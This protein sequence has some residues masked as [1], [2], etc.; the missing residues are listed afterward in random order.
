MNYNCDFLKTFDGCMKPSQVNMAQLINVIETNVSQY[1]YHYKTSLKDYPEITIEVTNANIPHLLGLSKN[2]HN[3]LPD[4][5]AGVIFEGLKDDWTLDN[6]KKGDNFWFTENQDKIIGVLLLY[7]IFHV[8]E[9]KIYSTKH[10]INQPLG[11]KFKRDNIYFIIFKLAN[12]KDYSVELSPINNSENTYFPRSLKIN[13]T[14]FT[15]CEEINMQL[16]SQQRI[17]T[18]KSKMKRVKW[19]L[20]H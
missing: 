10:I 8:Q 1:K 17:T 4:Y 6:L 2:H 12:N 14:R 3:G 15:N 9:C 16:V 18:K 7:Q 19:K 13:D 11:S 5:K 20:D